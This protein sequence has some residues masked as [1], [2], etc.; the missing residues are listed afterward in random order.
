M[1]VVST[2]RGPFAVRVSG[3]A[4]RQGTKP[5]MSLWWLQ[6]PGGVGAEQGA[7]GWRDVRDALHCLGCAGHA[8]VLLLLL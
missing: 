2:T 6:V 3:W 4:A 1:V 7:L 5:V 8:A